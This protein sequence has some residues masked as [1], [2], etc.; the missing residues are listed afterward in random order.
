MLTKTD[1]HDENEY[2]SSTNKLYVTDQLREQSFSPKLDNMN[3]YKDLA[4]P[5][6]CITI[7][8]DQPKLRSL[9]KAVLFVRIGEQLPFESKSRTT[10]ASK[11]N[12]RTSHLFA[13]GISDQLQA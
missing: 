6:S 2:V 11:D 1:M 13:I 9:A 5:F 12:T 3:L 4:C 7:S 8:L 10:R